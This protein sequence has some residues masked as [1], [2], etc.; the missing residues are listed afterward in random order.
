[1]EVDAFL[2]DSVVVA[3]GKLYVQGAGWNVLV[4]QQMPFRQNRIG[5]GVVIQVPYTQT[6]QMH[7]LSI[8]LLDT[9][10]NPIV[11][12]AVIG[13]GGDTDPIS[14]IKG[15]FNMGR[16]PMLPPGESQMVPLAINLDGV[17]F[18]SLGKY[19]VSISID[20]TEVKRLPML[21]ST[22]PQMTGFPGAP[23]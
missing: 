16:P 14:E 23:A 7:S 3:E 4:A 6:N 1:M 13:E 5:V 15:Q 20:G 17:E 19:N 12:G 18:S 2:A 10:E 11:L 21:V 9:D 22:M 8:R